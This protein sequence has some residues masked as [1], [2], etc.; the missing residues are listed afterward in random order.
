MLLKFLNKSLIFY[1]KFKE[2]FIKKFNNFQQINNYLNHGSNNINIKLYKSY[3][4]IFN[5][6]YLKTFINYNE[7]LKFI[8]NNYFWDLNSEFGF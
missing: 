8:Y 5:K 3:F 7:N 6:N 4:N 2:L 1:N